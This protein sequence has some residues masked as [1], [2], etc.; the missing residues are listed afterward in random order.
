MTASPSRPDAFEPEAERPGD[1]AAVFTRKGGMTGRS[2]SLLDKRWS[3]GVTALA[4]VA[5]PAFAAQGTWD[6]FSIGNAVATD[7]TVEPMPFEQAGASFP[8]S[9]FYY[10]QL[11]PPVPQIGEGIHSDAEDAPNDPAGIPVARAMRIDNSGVDRT[12]A[13][14]CLTAAIYYEAASEPDS[15][16]RAVAQVVLNRVAHPAY[17]NTVCGVVYQGSERSTGCQFSFTCDGSLARGPVAL[18]WDRARAVA[19][20]A[21][22]GYVYA[23]VGLATHYHTVQVHPYWAA[24][25][26]YLGTIGAHRFYAFQGAAGRPGTFRFA[27]FGGEPLPAPHPRAT[28]ETPLPTTLDPVA[29]ERAFAAAD[30]GTRTGAATPPPAAFA[31][32]RYSE[33]VKAR[34]GDTLYQARNL[35]ETQGIKAEYANSGRW[36]TQQAD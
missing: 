34:G 10:L 22:A 31:Q 1:F 11:D 2:G 35:P 15:G 26:D 27:Y 8:G 13:E 19:R 14:Q 7:A 17:P 3:L 20:A 30:Q 24:S 29:I 18:F 33:D 16:Q 23:P 9:A 36:L 6:R 25:L 12:R 21:L 4:V 28:V 32:P 5:L